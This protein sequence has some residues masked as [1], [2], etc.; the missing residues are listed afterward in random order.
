MKA[1]LHFDLRFRT[2]GSKSFKLCPATLRLTDCQ[3]KL[4]PST[5]DTMSVDAVGVPSGSIPRDSMI[6]PFFRS[7]HCP[8]P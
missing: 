6:N 4:S 3:D 7:F 5:L 8:R 1:L 2:T